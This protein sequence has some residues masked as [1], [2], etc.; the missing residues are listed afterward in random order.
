MPR[1]PNHRLSSRHNTIPQP[2]R[3]ELGQNWLIDKR[4]AAEI[5]E[6]LRHAPPLPVLELGAGNGALT[7][8]LVDADL[9]VVSV[10]VDGRR[11]G[12]LRR[13]LSGR[14]EILHADML[15]FDFGHRAHNVVSNVPFSITTPVLRRLLPQSD[16]YTAV[17]VLQ[18]EVAKK[19]AA[20]GGTTMLTAMWWPWYAFRLGRRIASTSFSPAP[21]VDA[22]VLIIER[23]TD[24]LLPLA[25]RAAYQLV[26]RN[27]FTGAGLGIAG[28]LRRQGIPGRH[29]RQWLAMERMNGSVLPRKLNA[30]NWV[31]LYA[32]VQAASRPGSRD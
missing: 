22:G 26:V 28:I 32:L 4:C 23:R 2:G 21:S 10:E 12:S 16:W 14:A 5:A 3:H 20:V 1:H 31:S 6:I 30:E 11:V 19:R 24:P 27:T 15:T 8:A 25:H 17:L 29:L 18:W 7:R 9:N 13:S